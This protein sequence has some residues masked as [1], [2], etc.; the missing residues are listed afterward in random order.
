MKSHTES[1]I[2][3][4]PQPISSVW[5]LGARITWVAL[6]PAALLFT[7]YGIIANGTGW[8]T[9]LDAFFGVVV[10]LMLLGRWVDHRSGS[11]TTLMGEPATD[12]QF[13]KYLAMLP[14]L[15]ASLW[16]AA[17]ALGNHVLG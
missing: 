13:R 5:V 6:G 17:N 1:T 11:S 9:G 7:T 4:S 2:T 10:G 14:P 16:I 8:L 15:A 3:K 12:Q